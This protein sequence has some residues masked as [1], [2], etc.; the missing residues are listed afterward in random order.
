MFEAAMTG[1]ELPDSYKGQAFRAAAVEVGWQ[2]LE[3]PEFQ[4]YTELLLAARTDPELAAVVTPALTAFDRHRRETTE[5]VLPAGSYD[6]DDLQLARDVVRYL[7]E[8]VKQQNSIMIDREARIEALRHF[9]QML[10]ASTPGNEFLQAVRADWR[11]QHG[12][13]D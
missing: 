7:T 3:T 2:Q 12:D 1:L 11:R 10:V 8:G 9:L 4:A 6:Q 5:R 13:A